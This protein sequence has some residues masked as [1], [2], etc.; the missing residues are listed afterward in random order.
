MYS[1]AGLAALGVVGLWL[2]YLVPHRLRHRQQLLESRTEDRYSGSMRVLAVTD[3][4]EVRRRA[5]TVRPTTASGAAILTPGRGTRI[6]A[7]PTGGATGG[8]NMDRPHESNEKRVVDARRRIAQ[9]HAQR[10]AVLERRA[11]GARRRLVL[12]L[13]LLALTVGAWTAAG[14]GAL[15]VP[16]LAAIPTVLLGATLA[17]G[18][19][20]VLSGQRADAA[21]AREEAA[22]SKAVQVA[23]RR[24]G[25]VATGR[26]VRGNDDDTLV[27][28]K[29]TDVAPATTSAG[30][31]DGA[32]WQPVPVPR[33]TYTLKAPAPRMEPAPLEIPE[34]VV[35]EPVVPAASAPAETA[36][37]RPSA[38]LDL[39]AILAR[40]RAV[41]E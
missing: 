35:A 5:Q 27:I 4:A 9:R 8:G 26:A 18:R 20:A 13:A 33:P 1:P 14:F 17:L 24:S 21:W 31:D 2:A 10:A 12:V 22:L 3:R 32:S 39:D 28:E 29:V 15:A 38:G 41:G 7:A 37:E 25:P 11:A 16:A 34:R 36:A 30:S 19:A 6:V 23:V 40:R